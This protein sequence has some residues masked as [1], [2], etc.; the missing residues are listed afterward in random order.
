MHFIE[1]AYNAKESSD[2][3]GHCGCAPSECVSVGPLYV[4]LICM[5]ENQSPIYTLNYNL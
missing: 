3:K 5:S 1:N 2:Q 4:S